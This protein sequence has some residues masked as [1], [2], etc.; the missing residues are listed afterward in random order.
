VRSAELAGHAV[1][2]QPS[3]VT[4]RGKPLALKRAL[5]NLLDNALFYGARAEIS[6]RQEPD[7]V[8]ICLRGLAYPMKRLP[9]CSIRMCG[10]RT[11]ASR[12]TAAWGWAWASHA[13]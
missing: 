12:M 11:G 10:W 13:A 1:A 5:G 2:W 9:V 7:W 3:G 6:V 4:V 8:L